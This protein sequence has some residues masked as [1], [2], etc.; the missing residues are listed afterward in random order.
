[1][2]FA[3]NGSLLDLIRRDIFIDEIRSRRWF[4]QLLDAVEY[5]HSRGV[6][7]R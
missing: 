2:E 5:C 1:M 7:H 6:V 4:T 3:H